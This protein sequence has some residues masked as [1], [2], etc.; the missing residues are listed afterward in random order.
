MY[1]NYLVWSTL[2]FEFNESTNQIFRKK[3]YKVENLI[4]TKNNIKTTIMAKSMT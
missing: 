2:R 1:N 4:G 3:S